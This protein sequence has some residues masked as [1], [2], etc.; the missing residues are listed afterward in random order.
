[1]LFM[2]EVRSPRSVSQMEGT[3]HASPTELSHCKNCHLSCQNR[4]YVRNG[5]YPY[6]PFVLLKE[7]ASTRRKASA[8]ADACQSLHLDFMGSACGC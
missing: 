1:M 5:W 8:H 6:S 7:Q 2:A 3:Q 4:M